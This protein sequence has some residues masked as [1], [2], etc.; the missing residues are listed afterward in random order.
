MDIFFNFLIFFIASDMRF[1]GKWALVGPCTIFLTR[2]GFFAKDRCEVKNRH[3][4]EN[5][6]TETYI[7]ISSL[8]VFKLI[9]KFSN[10]RRGGDFRPH[11]CPWRKIPV[12]V[13]KILHGPTK[14][15]FLSNRIGFSISDFPSDPI[16]N[17][18]TI[19]KKF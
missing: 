14:A 16:K 11:T 5:S 17:I 6:K 9:F 4:G 10:F 2:T 3:R 18:R 19:L 12:R 7:C 15:H 8:S 1:E 13:K